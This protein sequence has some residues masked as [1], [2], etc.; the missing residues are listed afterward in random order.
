MRRLISASPSKRRLKLR[1]VTGQCRKLDNAP[2]YTKQA[3]C[4]TRHITRNAVVRLYFVY[5]NWYNNGQETGNGGAATYTGGVEYGGVSQQITF[6]GQPSVVVPSGMQSDDFCYGVCNVSIPLNTSF[7][8]RT[9]VT[10]PN[11]AI[12]NSTLNG[13]DSTNGEQFRY[14][15]TGLADQTLGTGNLT[16]GTATGNFNISPI[17]ILAETAN[18]A[19]YVM[20]DSRNT[21]GR[22]FDLYTGSTGDI[23]QIARSIGGSLAYSNGATFGDQAQA[24]V[25]GYAAGT[26]KYT[27]RNGRR[28]HSSAICNL[29]INDIA[30]SYTAAQV[31]ANLQAI[32]NMLPGLPFF[33]C[34]VMSKCSSTDAWVT[35][36]NQTVTFSTTALN[37]LVRTGSAEIPSNKVFDFADEEM[38]GRDLD[39]W[40]VNGTANKYTADGLH[41]QTAMNVKSLTDGVID[42]SLIL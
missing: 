41:Q 10:N 36:I 6:L 21:A 20:G 11:G 39:K 42:T 22:S 24:M 33:L 2:S 12:V 26:R 27:I 8:A 35:T 9:Y 13:C 1:Q 37:A 18:K 34:T 4:R 7:F 31:Y 3:M 32:R 5:A 16:G 19:V 28:Y 38:G 30:S 15:T 23:G 14:A 25:T 17:L 29:G 40:I